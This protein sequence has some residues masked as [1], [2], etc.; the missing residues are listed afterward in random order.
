MDLKPQMKPFL[1]F[2]PGMAPIPDDQKDGFLLPP[3]RR[4]AVLVPDNAA[5]PI[6]LADQKAQRRIPFCGLCSLLLLPHAALS[7]LFL[8]LRQRVPDQRI[9]LAVLGPV[10]HP[11]LAQ[12]LRFLHAFL[13]D[14]IQ[15]EN[16]RIVQHLQ[17]LDDLGSPGGVAQRQL[18]V[19]PLQN[20]FPLCRH[21]SAQLG[22]CLLVLHHHFVPGQLRR[23]HRRHEI[24][25]AEG[26]QQ[27]VH[28]QEDPAEQDEQ[29]DAHDSTRNPGRNGHQNEKQH[30][31]RS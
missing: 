13:D 2:V 20:V 25:H 6:L 28:R 26:I 19:D 18:V 8:H 5:H 24:P 31:A 17:T 9:R 22:Q 7:L 11:L 4:A 21:L 10:L 3:G 30:L 15:P 12:T 14:L 27:H 23:R 1:R 16:L 29:G